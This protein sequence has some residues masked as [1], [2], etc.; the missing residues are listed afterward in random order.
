MYRFNLEDLRIGFYDEYSNVEF[1]ST[2]IELNS[3]NGK[4]F[5]YLTNRYITGLLIYANTC[6]TIQ[7][8]LNII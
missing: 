5:N 6:T 8:H 3:L 2:V 4:R 7:I 1:H